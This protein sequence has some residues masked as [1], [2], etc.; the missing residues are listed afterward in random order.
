[1]GSSQPNSVIVRLT[2]QWTTKWESGLFSLSQC[3]VLS[4]KSVQCYPASFFLDLISF[5]LKSCLLFFFFPSPFATN[6]FCYFVDMEMKSSCSHFPC[7]VLCPCYLEAF[8]SLRS[9]FLSK[10]FTTPMNAP[11]LIKDL[12]TFSRLFPDITVLTLR[13]LLFHTFIPCK[14]KCRELMTNDPNPLRARVIKTHITPYFSASIISHPILSP[15]T[16]VENS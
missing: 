5:V 3:W 13:C 9:A 7:I 11:L 2:R 6:A 8:H 15:K 4:L 16:R 1:M 10:W 12:I 14:R